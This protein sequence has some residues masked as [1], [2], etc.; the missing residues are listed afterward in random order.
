MRADDRLLVVT[1]M[2]K[3]VFP[4]YSF[5]LI[6]VKHLRHQLDGLLRDKA[7]NSG[8]FEVLVVKRQNKPGYRVR[9]K[10]ALSIKHLIQNHPEGPY[11]RF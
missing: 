10:R 1:E 8:K 9:L 11:I 4:R 5:E 2:L 6:F 7:G 3:E